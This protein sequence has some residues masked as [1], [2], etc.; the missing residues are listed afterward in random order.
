MFE[1]YDEDVGSS[2]LLCKTDPID[3]VDLVHSTELT[4][5]DLELFDDKMQTAGNMIIS[6]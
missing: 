2:D 1:A 5:F 6:T 4:K 3:F